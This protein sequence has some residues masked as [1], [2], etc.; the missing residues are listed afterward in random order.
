MDNISAAIMGLVQGISEFLPISSTAHLM[1]TGKLL[2]IN[3]NDFAK[4]FEVIIQFGSIL[5]VLVLYWRKF[6]SWSLLKKLLVAFLPTAV[7]GLVFYKI[8]KT[9][10]MESYTLISWTLIL[11]GLFLIIF[12]YFYSKKHKEETS[13]Q[14]LDNISYK[15]CL[16]I[17]LFQAI[18]MI[19]GVSRSA[20]T[21][22]GGLSLGLRRKMIV[23]FSFLLAVPTML[24]AS[25]LVLVKNL[26][27]FSVANINYL[28][29]GFIISFI[30]ALLSIKFLL[31]YI[32]KNN[33]IPF[34][35]YRIIAG[36]LFFLFL[37]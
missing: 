11:G 7:L 23:E 32:R 16:L 6:L 14:E 12:E 26:S 34:G 22:I 4:A 2:Q 5:A 10:L 35:I 21:I 13:D 17:G 29:V 25:A 24:A 28:V 18:A 3:Q 37:L 1:F 33:F 19:P 15:N 27:A 20:A 8:I 31:H 36:L 30:V 9:Y